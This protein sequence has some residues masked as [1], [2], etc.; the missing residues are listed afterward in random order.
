MLFAAIPIPT[1][2]ED[3]RQILF[4]LQGLYP[5]LIIA[6][7]LLLL[8]VVDL[9]KIMEGR[10]LPLFSAAAVVAAG[11]LLYVQE[12]LS[13]EAAEEGLFLGMLRPDSL[14][15]F[16]R[17]LFL[18]ATLL[19]LWLSHG[20]KAGGLLLSRQGEYHMLLLSLLLGA[21]LMS[22]T[23]NLLLIYLSIELVSISSY[24]LTNFNFNRKSAEAGLKYL[25]FGAVASAV[26]LFGISL[27]YGFTG[28]LDFAS[29]P[30]HLS[31][32]SLRIEALPLLVASFMTLSGFL[33][34]LSAVPFHIWAPDVYEGAPLPV[35][36]LFS[37]VPKL[38]GLSLLI[39]FLQNFHESSILFVS[40]HFD[41][42]LV[43]AVLAG[44]S[45]FI[46][47]L[48]AV[49]QDNVKRMLAYSSI[50]HTGFLLSGLLAYSSL[51]V[52]SLLFYAAIYLLMNFAA[53]IL[54]N[55]LY[56]QTGNE[57]IRGFSGLGKKI[58]YLG[59]A[60]VVVM[61]ALTGLPPTAGFTAKLLVFTA[62]W[63]AYQLSGNNVL[64]Y[65]L[66][67]GVINTIIALFYYLKIPYFMYFRSPG[68]EAVQQGA[69]ASV[70]E[71]LLLGL[72]VSLLL[73]FFFK[74][75]WL[76]NE[77]NSIDFIF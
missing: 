28:T 66:L 53:F 13:I 21:M 76:L 56:K 49:W 50:A 64:A 37:V 62:L 77:V 71:K 30:F 67:A 69:E 23:T 44:L 26:M 29:A 60:L 10:L 14:S 9:L 25:L 8:V 18:L 58:P 40:V 6:A 47:N 51:G 33:F 54:V 42:Q 68:Q 36:A 11:I 61:I 45:M 72:L 43:L 52:R 57:S 55:V 46:G 1:L 2:A 39:R 41:W 12:P 24:L 15:V 17:S 5:E 70:G 32:L 7:F 59:A 27:L 3:L 73:L 16:L 34:K 48:A 19:A 20:F 63:D 75:D 65:L 35:A 4:S 22:M 38:A 74:A 31:L